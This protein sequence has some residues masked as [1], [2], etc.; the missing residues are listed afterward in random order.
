[1]NYIDDVGGIEKNRSGE[2][3]DEDVRKIQF[4]GKSTYVISLPKRWVNAMGLK[5]GSQLI[6]VQKG[7]SLIL[8]PKGMG[9]MQERTSEATIKI[10]VGDEASAIAR[11]IIAVYLLGY[12]FIHIKTGEREIDALQRAAVKDLTRKKLVGTEIIS[13]T[14]KEIKMQVLV[15][16]PDLPVENAIRRMCLIAAFMHEKAVAALKNLDTKLA[17]EVINLDDEVDRF[18]LYVVRQLKAA[19]QNDHILHDIGLSSPQDCLGYRVIVKFVER[20]ADHATIIAKLVLESGTKVSERDYLKVAEMSSFA[21]RA[22][23]NAVKALFTNDCALAEEV[24]SG[25]KMIAMMEEQA[26]KEA[27]AKRKVSEMAN[28]R[29]VFESIRRCA[30]YACDIAEVVIN[31]NIEKSLEEG[32]NR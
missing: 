27:Q 19:V 28:M 8:T 18:S 10:S 15:S 21:R 1:M 9:R 22:F 3:L 2:Q 7:N 16:Y 6:L 24:I 26:I 17:A 29:M 20:I 32:S 30:E 12:K 31:L 11:K 25:G 13:E 4:T 23:E 14:E 5:T